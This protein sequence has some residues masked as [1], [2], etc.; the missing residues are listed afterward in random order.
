VA[1]FIFEKFDTIISS[2]QVPLGKIFLFFMPPHEESNTFVVATFD[3][4]WA[5][6]KVP[7]E[8][9]RCKYALLIEASP[10]NSS[11]KYVSCL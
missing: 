3:P 5:N 8:K 11:P 7:M 1:L 10:F 9:F 2:L 6:G 4:N